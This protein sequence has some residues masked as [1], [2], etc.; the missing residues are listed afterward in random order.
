LFSHVI[1]LR[2]DLRTNNAWVT[3]SNHRTG[4]SEFRTREFDFCAGIGR[5][6]NASSFT[7]DS[8]RRLDC[9]ESLEPAYPVY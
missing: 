5:R 8:A 9:G 2:P 1:S 4:E 6:A 3:G 7:L